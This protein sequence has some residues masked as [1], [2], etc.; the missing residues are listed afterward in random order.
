[1]KVSIIIPAYQAA[2]CILTS[3]TSALNQT[4]RDTE[5]IVVDDGSED[6][7][8]AAL[9]GVQDPRLVVI[10]QQN[11]G[12]SAALNRGVAE[13]TGDYIKF[14]DADDWINPEHVAAQAA[15]L[16]EAPNHIASCRWGYFVHSHSATSVRHEFTNHDYDDPIDWLIDSLNRDEGMMGGWMWLIPRVVWDAAGG[17]DESL[18]LNNDFDFSIR[19]LLASRGVRFSPEAIYSYREQS[20][21]T[22]SRQRSRAAMESAFKTTELGCKSILARENSTRTRRACADRWQRWE[23]DFYPTHSDLAARAADHVRALG[24]SAFRMQG[25]S[26]LRLLR[27]LI[28]WRAVR[29]LQMAAYRLG[30]QRVLRWKVDRRLRTLEAENS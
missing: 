3:V 20:S 4:H 18:S 8:S 10:R 23:Y 30:W 27:P 24:G 12:Q 5:V 17:W 29:R 13:S 11:R 9:A 28:G 21:Q 1:M 26:L 16:K 7:T 14:L 22:L 15:R 19:T 2:R 6:G 25:G